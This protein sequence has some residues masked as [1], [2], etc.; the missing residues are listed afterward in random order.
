MTAKKPSITFLLFY[1]IR[2]P[3][4]GAKVIF[5]YANRL[6]ADGYPVK[7]V[8]PVSLNFR[9]K[10][11]KYKVLSV[12]RYI[13]ILLTGYSCKN[14]YELDDRV[15]EYWT[16]SLNY[17]HIP[18][19]DIYI[20][21]EARTA[22]Y[23]LQYPIENSRKYYFI[24]GYENWYMTD[25][26]VRN[27]Y[28][29]PFNK[30][31]ISNWLKNIIENEEREKCV[32]VPNGFDPGQF[33]LIKPIR[34]RD[35]YTLSMLYHVD[36]RKGIKTGLSALAIVKQKYPQLKVLMFG[37]Y[38]QPAELPEWVQYYRSPSQEVHNKLNNEAA[39]YI[40]TSNTEGWG[41][42]VGEAM[43]CGQAVACTDNNGYKEMAVDGETALLSPV[44]DSEKLAENIIRLID[45][46]ELRYR[47]AGNGLIHMQNFTYDKS[48]KK[49]L[50][51]LNL[52]Q[53]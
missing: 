42:T 30:I 11:I 7:I 48:Y 52:P 20:A 10:S 15:K 35:K 49:M 5:D 16:F 1:C 38:P 25:S 32:F 37:A 34:E 36:A 21:T 39:I 41:L 27:T 53:Q 31:V 46:D 22:P 47:I 4:G 2:I 14:W 13:R 8:Y 43:M 24:Q 29:F 3:G 45:D 51:A 6:A 17:R 33:K 28:H 12:I 18:K 9:A 50:L 26:E 40:G 19:S 23:L 44:Q